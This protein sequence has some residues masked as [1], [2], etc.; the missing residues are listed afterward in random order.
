M[1]QE[2]SLTGMVLAVSPVGDFDRRAVLLTKERGKIT[3]F[4]KGA[5]RQGSSM[6]AA[7]SPLSFGT[8]T[9]YEGRTA[10]TMARAEITNYFR[11]LKEDLEGVY[12]GF[13]FLELAAYYGRENIDA[14]EMLNLLYVSLRALERG[15]VPARLVRCVFE[16]RLMVI[17]GEFPWDTAYGA[18]SGEAARRALVFAAETPLSR[19]YT[20]TLRDDAL[21]ELERV[22]ERVRK[23]QID[24]PLKSLEIL[25]AVR[26]GT[27]KFP[28]E[29][30]KV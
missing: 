14:S 29:N 20:F 22:Q 27:P 24:R 15:A 9:L 25:E 18:L 1:S 7:V 30:K 2:I 8:F 13:Y 11:K 4:A 28:I 10:Y 5:R 19:L 16:I 3:A 23:R 21:Q 6:L 17:N 26:F 12:Y